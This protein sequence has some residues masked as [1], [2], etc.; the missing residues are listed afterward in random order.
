M[1]CN[2]N[3]SERCSKLSKKMEVKSSKRKI[4][5][6]KAGRVHIKVKDN[7]QVYRIDPPNTVFFNENFE[8]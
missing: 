7:N 2:C 5:V 4:K 8:D 1:C 3:E 6:D